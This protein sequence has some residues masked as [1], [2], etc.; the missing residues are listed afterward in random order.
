MLLK[1]GFEACINPVV[2]MRPRIDACP[3]S[4]IMQPARFGRSSATRLL[5]SNRS[6]TASRIA[7]LLLSG[8]SEVFNE[9]NMCELCCAPT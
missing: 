1:A 9:C 6:R 8:C 3:P 5:R 7:C 4:T 2:S